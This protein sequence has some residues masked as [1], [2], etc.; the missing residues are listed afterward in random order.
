[1]QTLQ[2]VQLVIC[3]TE[4]CKDDRKIKKNATTGG[5]N[6]PDNFQLY[7]QE[8]SIKSSLSFQVMLTTGMELRKDEQLINSVMMEWIGLQ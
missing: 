4:N 2:Q 3:K 5:C 6:F 7:Q 1:V 8:K